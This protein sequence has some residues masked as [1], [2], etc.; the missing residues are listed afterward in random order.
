MPRTALPPPAS[1]AEVLRRITAE[2]GRPRLTWY[3]PDGERVELS[4]HVL[5]NWVAKTAN[6]LVEEFD[7]GPG[8]TVLLDLPAHWRTVV[9]AFAGWRCG[10]TVLLPGPNDSGAAGVTDGSAEHAPVDVVVSTDPARYPTASTVVAVSLPALA[11]RFEGALPAGAIDA[12]T[13]VMTYGD[14]LGWVPETDAAR[15]ALVSGASTT[16]FGTLLTTAQRRGEHWSALPRVAVDLSRPGRSVA[17]TLLDVLGC[18]AADGSAVLVDRAGELDPL[19]A[20][21]H[22]TDRA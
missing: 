4:G 22:G 19:V 20:M 1:V 9:W 15:P 18:L 6:L 14:R 5:D 13:S 12:A 11:R 3:G 10:A 7:A 17:D 16:G 2:P 21:E 8:H